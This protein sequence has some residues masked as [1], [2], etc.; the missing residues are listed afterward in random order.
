LPDEAKAETVTNLIR[1]GIMKTF[2]RIE[3]GLYEDQ[4]GDLYHDETIARYRVAK[5]IKTDKYGWEDWKLFASS[6]SLKVS[7]EVKDNEIKD[8]IGE[9]WEDYI[10]YKV[11]DFGGETTVK[12][13]VY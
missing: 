12:R 1:G 8:N 3:E 13:L 4:N 6:S 5:R 7:N 11:V 10:E 9:I 2:K